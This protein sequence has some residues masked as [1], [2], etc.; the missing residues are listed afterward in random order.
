VPYGNAPVPPPGPP[1]DVATDQ[2]VPLEYR[3]ALGTSK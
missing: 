3:S 1:G 2:P